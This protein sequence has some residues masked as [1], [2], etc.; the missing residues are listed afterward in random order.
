MPEDGLRRGD[1]TAMKSHSP[2]HALLLNLLAAVMIRHYTSTVGK[3]LA[4]FA[5]FAPTTSSRL[6]P[7]TSTSRSR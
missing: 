4:F 6:I 5:I 2:S 1:A 3:R 7:N